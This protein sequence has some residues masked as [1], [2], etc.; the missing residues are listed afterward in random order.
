MATQRLDLSPL[1]DSFPMHL[2]DSANPSA[3]SRATPTGCSPSSSGATASAPS[4]SSTGRGQVHCPALIDAGAEANTVMSRQLAVPAS[5]GGWPP[6][7]RSRRPAGPHDPARGGHE[8]HARSRRRPA[9]CPPG[10][11][12][13]TGPARQRDEGRQTGSCEAHSV[14]R[15]LQAGINGDMSASS[16][17]P[18]APGVASA[19]GLL[20]ASSPL[21]A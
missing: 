6:R 3:P 10:R 9:T 13:G 16:R 2:R 15:H 5:P 12:Q 14:I 18:V 11:V 8:S 4:P 20:A 19:R 1:L 7:M 21:A 17:R